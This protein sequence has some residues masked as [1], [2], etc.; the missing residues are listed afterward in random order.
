MHRRSANANRNSNNRNNLR[1][2][3]RAR[4]LRVCD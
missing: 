3:N 1:S 2:N 4:P